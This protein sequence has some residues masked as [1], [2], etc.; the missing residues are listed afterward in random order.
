MTLCGLRS[1]WITPREWANGD[2][3]ADLL[4]DGEQLAERVPLNSLCI[5]RP[6]RI[7]HL[8]EARPVHELHRVKRPAG[9]VE[10]ELVDRD[11]VGVFELPGDLRL[12]E[13]SLSAGG[14]PPGPGPCMTFIATVRWMRVSVA[15]RTSPI[16]PRAM[17]G[18]TS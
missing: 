2:G 9:R 11:D 10:A 4:K 18:P 13:E 3:V 15:W 8:L 16:P 7:E 12:G 5:A 1:R 6:Q 17:T 14:Q